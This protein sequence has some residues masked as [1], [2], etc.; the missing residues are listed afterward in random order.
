MTLDA[1]GLQIMAH[2]F[3]GIAEEMGAVLVSSALSPNVRERRDSSAALFTADGEMVAQAA[4]IPVHLGAMPE[5]VA[6]VR[7]QDPRPGDTFIINDPYTGGTHLPDITLVHAIAL[8]G[9]VVGYTVVRAHHSDVGGSRPGSMPPHSTEVFQEGLVIPP[10]RW[11]SGGRIHGDLERLILANVRTPDI[12][13]GDLAAQRAACER[14]ADRYRELVARYGR[15]NVEGAV[16]DLLDYA[17]RQAREAIRERV[18]AGAYSAEDWLEGDGVDDRDVTIRVRVEVRDGRLLCDFAGTD[19]AVRGNVNCPLSVTRSAALF[20][21]RCLVDEDLSRG[22]VGERTV[23]ACGSRRERRDVAAYHRRV[24]S[25]SGRCCGA[26]R[27]GA[28]DHEQRGV[29]WRGVD[30]LRNVGWWARGFGTGPG[31]FGCSCRHVQHPKHAYRSVGDGA[32]NPC[33]RICVAP[34]QWRWRSVPRR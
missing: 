22:I 1:I 5:A 7:A 31:S 33:A 15:E 24:V 23:A 4:H 10:V 34:E 21:T 14:G 2:A 29:G 6:A 28:G 8:E 17:E 11:S 27:P 20:V 30:L 26:S 16:R 13:R 18:R 25:G 19:S 9:R 12:R 3:A 32:S